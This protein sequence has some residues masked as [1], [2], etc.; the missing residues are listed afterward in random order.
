MIAKLIES[1]HAYE[2]NNSVYFRVEAFKDY[3]KLAN[4]NFE[5]IEENMLEGGGG[6]GPNLKKG[7]DEK[8][9]FPVTSHYG[10]PLCASRWRGGVGEPVR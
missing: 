3:G 9:S 2:K 10:K 4:L 5:E 1:G 8:E 6:S 7:A